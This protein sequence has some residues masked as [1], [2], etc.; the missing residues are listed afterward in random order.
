[1][2]IKLTIPSVL[3]ATLS[4]SLGAGREPISRGSA[5]G[6]R[7][8]RRLI[9]SALPPA[10]AGL[11]PHL[12]QVN[13]RILGEKGKLAIGLGSSIEPCSLGHAATWAYTK[14]KLSLLLSADSIYI[15]IE[16]IIRRPIQGSLVLLNLLRHH[17]M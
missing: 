15:G 16:V 3:V 5:A 8:C 13:S 7:R 17:G 10:L 6:F 2:C 4:G 12:H 9:R 1:M 14:N 11:L